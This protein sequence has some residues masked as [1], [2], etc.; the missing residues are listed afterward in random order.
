MTRVA[1][2]GF[3]HETNTFAPF[4]TT[5]DLFER[6]GAWPEIT[7]GDAIPDRFHGLNIPL[8]GFLA[9]CP[10]DILPILWAGA[11]PG[12]FV[13]EEAFD[14]IVGE[15]VVGIRNAAPDAVYLDL[16]GAMVTEAHPDAEAEILRRIRDVTGPDLPIA[17]SL[18]LHGNLSQAFFD[19]ASVVTVYRSY[20]HTDMAE[21]GA[22]AARLLDAA[23][24]GPVAKAFRR[25][26]YLIPITAQSTEFSPGQELYAG[27]ATRDALSV[28]L[29]LGFPPADV[30]E[31]GPAIFAYA[32]TQEAADQAADQTAQH[33]AEV[34]ST[35]DPRLLS[36]D[37]AV[38]RAQAAHPG[39]VVIAD[40]Q[41]NP[42][43]G[44]TGETTGL[45]RA[46]IA[47]KVPDAVLSMLY[48]PE[49]AA[50]AHAAGEG[51]EITVRLGGQFRE[52]SEPLEVKVKVEALSDG[53][54]RFTG[55]MFGGSDA[56]L[57]PVAR[58]RLIGTG[59][60]V[61][62][63]SQRAQNADQEMFRVVGIE[64]KEHAIIC[65]KSAVHFMADYLRVTSDILFAD[66]TGANPCNL[67]SIPYTQ[68]RLPVR[69][70]PNGPTCSIRS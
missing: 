33:L 7:R 23:L 49:A 51:A 24:T 21:T 63:G 60:T 1:V 52:Y 31:L 6:R 16:H 65:V 59:I 47:A 22:R 18:D 50:A 12:G 48:D 58:L 64:P 37:A 56:S 17:V 15:I 68:L 20:P 14:T 25:G 30:P 43:A 35:F 40:V 38:A 55:P 66:V 61:V 53:R 28:D 8:S 45:L 13:T 5:L 11:E 57:G 26:A 46:L 54:F 34:E 10:H 9:A 70:G 41:D 29:A 4:P 32:R 27:L 19:R 3:Q 44:G 36:A 69:L 2:A 67:A 42:G 62:V 39:P